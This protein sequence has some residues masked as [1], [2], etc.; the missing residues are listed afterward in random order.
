[1]TLV[2]F[3]LM[4]DV[5]FLLRGK[6]EKEAKKLLADWTCWFTSINTRKNEINPIFATYISQNLCII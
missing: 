2:I 3:F 1:M 4:W 5:A 6:R